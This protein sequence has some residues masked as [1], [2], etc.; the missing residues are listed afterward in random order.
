MSKKKEKVAKKNKRNSNE[1][2][3]AAKVLES[4]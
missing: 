1:D 4:S 3:E 2:F